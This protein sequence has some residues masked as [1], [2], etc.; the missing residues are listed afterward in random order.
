[1]HMKRL[2]GLVDVVSREMDRIAGACVVG[3]MVLVIANI[4]LRQVFHR[5]VLGTYE[6]VGFLTALGV[7]LALARCAFQ[8]GHIAL[9]YIASRLPAKLQAG[10]GI[11]V[12]LVSF[13]FWALAAWRLGVYALSL[14]TSGVVSSTAQ[15][16]LYPVAMLIGAGLAGLCLVPLARLLQCWETVCGGS[17]SREP[18]CSTYVEPLRKAAR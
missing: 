3:V 5:P 11:I 8:N 13:C 4:V 15:F 16:P 17:T 18:V 9:D 14:K 12:N 1:M 2:A 7:S 6:I 10:A